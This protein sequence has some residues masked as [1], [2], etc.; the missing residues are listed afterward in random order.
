MNIFKYIP[1]FRSNVIW[2]KI[3][4]SIY[5]MYSIYYFIHSWGTM[6]FLLSFPFGFF[7]LLDM[8]IGNNTGN[9][10]N[11]IFIVSAILMSIGGMEVYQSFFNRGPLKRKIKYDINP[12][13]K[14]NNE[15]ILKIHFLDIGQGDSILIQ[16]SNITMLIDGSNWINGHRIC[17]Y[18][19]RHNIYKLDYI[20]ATHPHPDHIG[21][22]PTV[23]K[24]F[25]IK[26][27]IMTKNNPYTKNRHRKYHSNLLNMAKRYGDKIIHP[28]PGEIF[29]LGKARLKILAPNRDDYTRVNNHSIVIKLIFGEN[30]FLLTGDAE[31]CSE[32][33]MMKK[34]N[35]SAD[36]LKV[37]HHGSCTS[38][39]EKFI[40]AVSPKHAII[41]VGYNSFYGQPD[42][43]V[44]ERLSKVN[45]KLYRTDKQ[46]TIIV[47]SD[48]KEIHFNKEDCSYPKAHIP[49]ISIREKYKLFHRNKP[50]D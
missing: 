23:L 15:D 8:I 25:P 50:I 19:N 27:I 40:R 21:G 28:K 43:C 13:D 29:N 34:Y 44:L 2:K 33:E 1:G 49:Y 9:N 41:S 32:Y 35:V 4:A 37:G 11:I 47:Q 36:V 3:I 42:K 14:D 6:M 38:S 7:S 30:V 24:T 18:L 12:F 16:Q 10:P 26:N 46:G 22:L 45:A 17:K 31:K 5:Y 48:G 20:I 39:S